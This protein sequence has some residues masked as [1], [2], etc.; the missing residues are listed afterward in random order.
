METV[1]DLLKPLLERWIE[2]LE[3]GAAQADVREHGIGLEV[4]VENRAR[5][6]P[7]C[8]SG[9]APHSQ[10][11]VSEPGECRGEFIQTD[12]VAVHEEVAA[13]NFAVSG[14]VD[15]RASAIARVD[16]G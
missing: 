16:R 5:D 9:Y 2:E 11:P 8:H 1:D 7:R 10:R 3:T 15:E 4:V 12:R 13:A 6:E 14:K